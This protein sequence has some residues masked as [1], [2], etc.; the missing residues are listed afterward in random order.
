MRWMWSEWNFVGPAPEFDR[1]LVLLRQMTREASD[2]C[3][4]AT[5]P[6]AVLQ[7]RYIKSDESTPCQRLALERP[8]SA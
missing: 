6:V 8:R 4:N 7:W 1:N 5:K 3:S 2:V